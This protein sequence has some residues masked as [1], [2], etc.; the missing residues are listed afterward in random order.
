MNV[1]SGLLWWHYGD[2]TP[3]PWLTCTSTLVMR[4]L[5]SSVIILHHILATVLS[6][7]GILHSSKCVRQLDIEMSYSLCPD[8]NGSKCYPVLHYSV[9]IILSAWEYNTELLYWWDSFLPDPN[10]ICVVAWTS[11]D[12]RRSRSRGIQPFLITFVSV[13]I[14]VAT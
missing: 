13:Q 1:S 11:L 5:Q 9:F 7:N 3:S 10:K 2:L 4:S 14:S 8:E 12:H 6:N